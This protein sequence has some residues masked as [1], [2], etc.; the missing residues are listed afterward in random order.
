MPVNDPSVHNPSG[1]GYITTKSIVEKEC[2]LDTDVTKARNFKIIN[3]SVKNPINGGAVG[4]KLVPHYSQMLLA[5]PSSFHSKRSEFGE[6]AVWVTKYQDRELFAAG[7]H[8]MQSLGGT[9]IKSA[10]ASRS[11]ATDATSDK[12][13][14]NVRDDDIVLWHTFGT[15]HNPRVEDWPVMPAEKMMVTLK[16]VNFFTRN[17]A[18]DVA[19]SK[20]EDNKST[21][22]NGVDA[23]CAKQRPKS[24]YIEPTFQIKHPVKTED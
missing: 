11:K 5:D 19:I 1:V 2:G 18:M 23:C 12:G 10:I 17:P 15:T 4:Y 24:R 14:N 6:H 8:T 7:E 22:A 3:E 16:P 13:A 21:L 20:Q 9:G